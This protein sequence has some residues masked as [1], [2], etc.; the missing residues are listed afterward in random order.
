MGRK[1]VFISYSHDSEEHRERVLALS[2]RLRLDGI[3][4]RLDGDVNGIPEQGWP[5]WML[6]QL[7]DADR[8]L[9]VCTE[10][11]YRRFRGHEEP[12]KGAD[13]EG[14]VLTQ[15]ICD[16]RRPTTTFLS[17]LFEAHQ[18][19]FIPEPLRGYTRYLLG[20]RP[21][22]QELVDALLDSPLE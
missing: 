12:G 19:T 15:E 20:S 18:E 5:R 16:A 14:A 21:A 17:V 9:V 6:E 8:V 10:T 3:E 13:W 7:E 2:E 1:V 11:Y 22:Y 4:T